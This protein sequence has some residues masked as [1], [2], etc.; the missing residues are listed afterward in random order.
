[1][2][3]TILDIRDLRVS[4]NVHAGKVRAIRGVDIEIKEREIVCLVGESGSGKSVT[5]KSIMGLLPTHSASVE[6]GNIYVDG[7]DVANFTQS[8][9]GIIRGKQAAMIFQD[10]MTALN[11]L[12]TIGEQIKEALL[13]HHI[14]EREVYN[15]EYAALYDSTMLKQKE[16]LDK[17]VNA[18]SALN[19]QNVNHYKRESIKIKRT[20]DKALA[21]LSRDIKTLRKRAGDAYYRDKVINI[22]KLVGIEHPESMYNQYP[23]QLSGGMR[24]RVVVAIALSCEPKLLI[25]DEPTTALDVTIQAQILELIRELQVKF[26][27]AVLFITHDLGVVAKMADKVYV[28]YAG[29]IVE[30][31]LVDEVFYDPRHP[32]T[33]GLLSSMPDLESNSNERLFSIP[34][35]PPNLINPPVGDAFAPRNKYALEIDFVSEPPMFEITETHCAATWL[36]DERAPK[37]ERP[38]AITDRIMRYRKLGGSHE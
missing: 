30:R 9:F 29:K 20:Y 16:A 4:F 3:R 11:P 22:L 6:E 38:V 12:V 23:H 35:T 25:A 14:P 7:L 27:F 5:A 34:G 13:L 21:S 1:M 10:P 2:S 26:N 33:W 36:L 18:K 15:D 31:G 19:A 17:F 24:Q 28:M 37:T 8:E 32:Y